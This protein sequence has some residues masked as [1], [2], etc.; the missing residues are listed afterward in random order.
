MQRR[1]STVSD[2][3]ACSQCP[4]SSPLQGLDE[5]GMQRHLLTW[6]STM[7]GSHAPRGTRRGTDER[8]PVSDVPQGTSVE[9][10]SYQLCTRSIHEGIS[11]HSGQLTR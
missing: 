9:L 10:E 7:L 2:I 11:L 4:S 1:L 5:A 8:F 3:C 6:R